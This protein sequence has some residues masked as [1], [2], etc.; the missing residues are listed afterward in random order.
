ELAAD[1]AAMLNE[2]ISDWK[3]VWN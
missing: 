2:C 3:K 1:K